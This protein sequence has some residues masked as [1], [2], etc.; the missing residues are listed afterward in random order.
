LIGNETSNDLSIMCEMNDFLECY[1]YDLC[2]SE[3]SMRWGLK[4]WNVRELQETHVD[5]SSASFKLFDKAN[6][7]LDKIQK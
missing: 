5:I 4:F 1:V 7:I 3:D 6:G 2:K